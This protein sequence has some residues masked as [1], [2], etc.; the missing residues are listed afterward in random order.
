MSDNGQTAPATEA[1]QPVESPPAAPMPP[2]EELADPRVRLL[3]L[4]SELM[5]TRNSRLVVEY[6]RLRRA[7]A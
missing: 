2:R 4:A 3:Q 1:T 7:I 6:L 5:R